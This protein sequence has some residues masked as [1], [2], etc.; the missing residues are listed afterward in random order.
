MRLIIP[1]YASPE[2]VCGGKSH[3][4]ACKKPKAKIRIESS[5]VF[6]PL[7]TFVGLFSHLTFNSQWRS[8]QLPIG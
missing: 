4:R 7:I 2:Q 1:E 6:S 5:F 3:P 8:G